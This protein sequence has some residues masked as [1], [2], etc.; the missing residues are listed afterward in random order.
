MDAARILEFGPPNVIRVENIPVPALGPDDLLV[1]VI[2][3]GINPIE[4]K[5][6]SG[7]MA[8]ALQRPLPVTLGWECAGIVEAVGVKVTQFVV[9]DAVFSYPEFARGGTHA[10]YVAI[11]ANQAAKKPAT[12]DF[13]EAASVPM[14]A[15]AA[16]TAIEISRLAAGE[17]ILIHGA[18]GAVGHWLVQLAKAKGA[19]VVGTASGDGV[20]RIAALGADTTVDYR[21]DKFEEQGTFDIVFDLVGGDTQARSWAVLGS[22]G[23]LVS[24]VSPP[25]KERDGKYGHFVFTPPRGDVLAQIAVMID[26]GDLA[27]L[28]IGRYIGLAELAS[29]HADAERGALGGKAIVSFET[30]ERKLK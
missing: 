4:W 28:P 1:R 21:T 12:L 6:R 27:C 18:G 11:A 10:A 5:I 20:A 7:A 17:R 24:T 26:A 19:V 16:W 2:A 30:P 25:A 14:T 3:S 22:G 29:V 13:A 15:Q 8:Q 9:G 23:R